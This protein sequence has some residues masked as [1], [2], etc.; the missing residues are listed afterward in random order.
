MEFLTVRET[1]DY[2]RVHP[3]TIRRWIDDGT[4]HAVHVGK[5]IRIKKHDLDAFTSPE[6]T[7]E[8]VTKTMDQTGLHDALNELSARVREHSAQC[9]RLEATIAE[10]TKAAA[11]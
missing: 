6:K 11:R 8:L 3:A 10:L 5:G 9:G 1:A 7:R 2:C 4:L